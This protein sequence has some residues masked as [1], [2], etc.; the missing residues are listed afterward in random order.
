[1]FIFKVV[2]L[3]FFVLSEHESKNMWSKFDN[4][5]PDPLMERDKKSLMKK[6]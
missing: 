3:I 6:N 1:M 4:V 5:T 2:T